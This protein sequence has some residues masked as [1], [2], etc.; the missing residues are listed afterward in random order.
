MGAIFGIEISRL[1]RS[2]AEVA[3]LME[4]AAITETLLIDADGIYDPGDVND[5]MLVLRLDHQ[6]P[7]GKQQFIPVPMFD[8]PRRGHEPAT[9]YLR[10]SLVLRESRLSATRDRSGRASA[11]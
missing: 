4:F 9:N 8:V 2:N 5:R 10:D 11:V 3:R 7:A 1:A 6:P